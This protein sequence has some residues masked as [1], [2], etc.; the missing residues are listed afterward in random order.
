MR[1][2]Q[3]KSEPCTTTAITPTTKA[4]APAAAARKVH[5][6]ANLLMLMKWVQIFLRCCYGPKKPNLT[7]IDMIIKHFILLLLT[8]LPLH[9]LSE[10]AYSN[11]I[12]KRVVAANM[13]KATSMF[14]LLLHTILRK[15]SVHGNMQMLNLAVMPNLKPWRLVN[16]TQKRSRKHVT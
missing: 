12:K 15:S 6:D 3:P 13:K 9:H 14:A 10:W 7:F 16:E 4:T 8:K 2:R 11:A 1:N 5:K